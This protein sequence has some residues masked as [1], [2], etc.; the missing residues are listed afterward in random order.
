[1]NNGIVARWQDWSGAGHEHLFLHEGPEVIVAE[2]M[3]LADL[4]GQAIALRYR[5][6][7]DSAWR[8]KRAEIIRIGDEHRLELVSDGFGNWADGSGTALP[9]LGGAIDIDISATPFT[10]T[11]P[12]RRLGLKPGESAEI[13]AVY[14]RVPDLAVTTD[15][16][17]YTRL[18]ERCYR[19]DSVDTDFTREVE[20]D[21]RGLVVNYPGLFRRER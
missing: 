20:V 6:T 10:N 8:V 17:R 14:V 2:S 5:I 16:Q 11:L 15:R 19:Y 13:L 3:I 18:G 12:I 4:D 7:C 1:M 9:Q 21:E